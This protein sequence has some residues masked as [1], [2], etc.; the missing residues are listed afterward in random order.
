MNANIY[1]VGFACAQELVR[2]GLREK[3]DADKQAAA[4]SAAA[5]LC[6]LACDAN[7]R[8]LIALAG[9][10]EPLVELASCGDDAQK[11]KAAAA[12]KMLAY[13]DPHNKKW[14]GQAAAIKPLVAM[15]APSSDMGDVAATDERYETAA[16]ALCN[17]AHEVPL[18]KKIAEAGAIEPLIAML[19]RRD[20]RS[21]E[22]GAVAAAAAATLN[23]LAYGNDENR[24]EIA[25]AGAI[26]PLVRLARYGAEQRHKDLAELALK[27]LAFNN[28]DNLV[29]I[30]KA[31]HAAGLAADLI[32]QMKDK[33]SKRAGER[34]ARA[35]QQ[36]ARDR[37]EA[38]E[39]AD[40]ERRDAQR[41]W[42]AAA[43]AAASVE[44]NPQHDWLVA[45]EAAAR[46]DGD[47]MAI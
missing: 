44:P 3:D 32:A 5:A 11:A 4:L 37:A 9:G 13:K 24:C 29:A 22:S 2:D 47:L 30:S 36:A 34:V 19:P 28:D 15:L 35:R 12:L 39:A 43:E 26:E 10:I 14:I 42:L 41:D 7:F 46:E 31:G 23:N 27:S 21:R 6:S 33:E 17:L 1:Q 25:K 38:A 16:S 20:G 18:R 8:K 40:T 45:A